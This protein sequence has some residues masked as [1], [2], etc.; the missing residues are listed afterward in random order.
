MPARACLGGTIIAS[1][2]CRLLAAKR[3]PAMIDVWRLGRN[4]RM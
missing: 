1:L 3:V 4:N 2:A